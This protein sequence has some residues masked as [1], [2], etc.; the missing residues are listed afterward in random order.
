MPWAIARTRVE[1]AAALIRAA[2]PV[3]AAVGPA[4]V[5]RSA[6][7]SGGAG[8]VTAAGGPDRW[9]AVAAAGEP[10][11]RAR[12]RSRGNRVATASPWTMPMPWKQRWLA[13]GSGMRCISWCRRMRDRDRNGALRWLWRT[14]LAGVIPTQTCDSGGHTLHPA[15]FPLPAT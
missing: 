7:S 3:V 11:R 2:I 6:V 8:E 10:A 14:Q 5:D 9:A 15:D 13:S 4:P 1:A 12:R